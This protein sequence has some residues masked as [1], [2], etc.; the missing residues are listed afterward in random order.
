MHMKYTRYTA[1]LHV[2]IMRDIKWYIRN[3]TG[4][5]ISEYIAGIGFIA[6]MILPVIMACFCQVT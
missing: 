6:L 4:I 5:V 2:R 1:S 3:Y